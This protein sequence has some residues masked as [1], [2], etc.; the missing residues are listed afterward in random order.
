MRNAYLKRDSIKYTCEEFYIE[1]FNNFLS[2][3]RFANYYDMDLEFA[4]AILNIGRIINNKRTTNNGNTQ[5][6]I[7]EDKD[8]G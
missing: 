2:I 6:N 8:N 3:E 5:R 1:Y 4:K 7:A